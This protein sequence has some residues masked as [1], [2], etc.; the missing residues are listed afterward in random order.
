MAKPGPQTPRVAPGRFWLGASL[1]A[2]A[3]AS[4]F[5][6][7]LGHLGAIAVPGCGPGSA[8]ARAAASAWGTIPLL[9]WP[10]SFLGVA[11]FSALLAAW[12]ASRGSV[13]RPLARIVRLVGLA[14]VTLVIVLLVESLFCPYCFVAHGACLAF[15][16]V[17]EASRSGGPLA[18][19]ARLEVSAAAIVFA[20]ATTLLAVAEREVRGAV[21]ARAER[22]LATSTAEILRSAGG[23]RGFTGRYRLGPE[24]ARAR[25]VVFTDYQCPDCA[26]VE[27]QLRAAIETRSDVSLSAKHF[28]MCSDCNAHAENDHPNACWAARAAEAAGILH[29]AGGFWRMHDWLFARGGAFTDADLKRALADLRFDEASFIATLHGPQ[30][31]AC[32]SADIEEAMRLGLIRTPM[33]FINGG[34]LRGWSAPDAI[35]RA[36]TDLEAHG[37]LAATAEADRPAEAREK[38]LADWR[39]QV[40]VPIPADRFPRA[41]GPDT[42]SVRIVVF[43][44]YQE[45]YTAEADIAARALVQGRNDRQYSFRHFPADR[46]CNGL[47]ER[48]IHPLACVAAKAAEA[49]ALLGGLDAFWFVHGWLMSHAS[50]FT[51]PGLS[52]AV[53]GFGLDPDALWDAMTLAEPQRAIEEDAS[54][55][56][57]LGVTS[58]P[59]IF[60]NGKR[61]PRF[62]LGEENLLPR[63]VEEAATR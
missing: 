6:M 45:P 47:A 31:L 38:C 62:R 59:L 61:V 14:S 1:L 25:I 44:D 57:T 5:A 17:A 39:E 55:A 29:G 41:L 9:H 42:A 11:A 4:D 30:T 8:C 35:A 28:P 22:D 18:T 40:V 26:R 63:I 24:Q 43:G 10:V 12:I 33:I 27:S 50:D 46:A 19:G 52:E 13:S 20:V 2:V 56:R 51:E 16:V 36:L 49:A 48:T 7:A 53:A 3:L 58:I 34:E 32:V 21:R 54:A 60:V 23:G 37:P 15:W